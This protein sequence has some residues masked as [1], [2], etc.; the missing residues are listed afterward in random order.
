[1]KRKTAALLALITLCTACLSGCWDATQLED[2]ATPIVI[3]MDAADDGFI[4]VSSVYWQPKQGE[5]ENAYHLETMRVGTL[6]MNRQKR[7]FS[8]TGKWT[9]GMLQCV[10]FDE[11]LATRGLYPYYNVYINDADTKEGIAVAVADGGSAAALLEKAQDAQSD[12]ALD[13]IDLM[14]DNHKD[15]V[16]PLCNLFAF[17]VACRSPGVQPVLP[18]VRRQQDGKLEITGTALF[19]GERMVGK[20]DLNQTL[21]LMLLREGTHNLSVPFAVRDETGAVR[22]RGSV[23]VAL[24]RHVQVRRDAQSG[25]LYYD[26]T[27]SGD[28]DITEYTT[29]YIPGDVASGHQK[30]RQDVAARIE[31]GCREVIDTVQQGYGVDSFGFSQ[32]ALARWRLDLQDTIDADFRDKAHINVRVQI[33]LVNSGQIR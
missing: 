31:Q 28:A 8:A 27:L 30:I 17:D 22:D 32:H 11:A 1:M 19:D 6:D 25:A 26:V 21:Y 3:G 18:L 16:L 7:V 9:L 4:N 15:S 2:L 23:Q 5:E 14:R 20:L 10:L 13:I 24:R 33:G 12:P 29:A